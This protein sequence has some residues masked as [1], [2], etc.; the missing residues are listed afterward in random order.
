MRGPRHL[1]RRVVAVLI[2]GL[3]AASGLV[4]SSQPAQAAVTVT[5]PVSGASITLSTNRIAAG[6]RIE[7]S[8]RGFTPV[9]GSTGEPLVAVRPYDFDAGPAWTVG[10]RDAYRP[11]N[12]SQPP[13][14]EAAYW[15]VTHHAD[16]GSFEGWLQ[17]PAELTPS[18]PLGNGQHWLR[19]LSGAFFTTTGDRVTDPITFQVPFTVASNAAAASTGLTSPTGIFQA[20]TTFRPGAQVTVRGDGFTPGETVTATLDGSPLTAGI[21]AGT[22][23]ALPPTARITLPSDVALGSRTLRLSTGSVGA[24]VTLRITAQP[25]ATL[26]TERVRPGGAFGF[27]LAGYIGVGGAPQKVAVVVNEQVLACV[28]TGSTG[29]ASGTATLPA[30]LTGTVVI[31]FNVGLSCVLPPAGVINDQP[32]SRITRSLTVDA[33][34]PAPRTSALTLTAPKSPRYGSARTATVALRIAGAPAAGTVEVS[35]GS[36]TTTVAVGTAGTRVTLPADAAVGRHTLTARF[37]GD[38]DT[39]AATAS[40]RFTVTKASSSASLK[41]SASKVKRGKRVDATVKVS[42]SGATKV[43]ATGT[44]RIYDGKKRLGSY[45]LKSSH[46]GTLKV[47]LP[48]FTKRGTH[49]IKAVFAGNSNA[50]GKTTKTVSVRVS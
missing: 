10:G 41:L 17:A 1:L 44:V 42:I 20:G 48:A 50:S 4:L 34:S 28:Q 19:I 11:P 16:G 36:W 9:Q 7:I 32:I 21:T 12:P 3:L 45:A 39:A 31:G 33:D 15:F 43:Y 26:R 22:D 14:S 24:E 18:G 5:D 38:A 46:R 8:G 25:S 27:D 35:Q 13:G 2:A 6:E 40:A 37:A 49:K 23:G 47:K 30:E 29:A